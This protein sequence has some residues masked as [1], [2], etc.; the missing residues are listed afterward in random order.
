MK[1]INI[2]ISGGLGR[3]GSL[4]IKKTVQDKQLQLSSVTEQKAL[5]KT[6]LNTKKTLSTLLKIQM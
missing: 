3:M 2:T 5:Q 4:L 1:K 6:A